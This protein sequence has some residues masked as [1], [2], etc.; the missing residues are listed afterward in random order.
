M[1]TAQSLKESYLTKY[2]VV[3][4]PTDIFICEWGL[5]ALP[6]KDIIIDELARVMAL[7]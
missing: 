7:Q 3:H 2:L 1:S 4:T 6:N 5:A